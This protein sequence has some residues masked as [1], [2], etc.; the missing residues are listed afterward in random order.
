MIVRP[1]D[2]GEVARVVRWARQESVSIVTRGGNTGLVGGSIARAGAILLS[3][4]RLRHLGEVDPLARQ[5]TVGAGA[6][7]HETQEHAA[8]YGLRYP[9]DFGA[10]GSA[11]IGG[12]IATNAGGVNVVRYGMTRRQVVGVEAVLG[13][14]EVVS[15]LGGLV[16]DNTGF[17]LA[18]LLCGSEGTL[19]VVTAARLQLVPTNSHV[20]TALVSCDDIEQAVVIAAAVCSRLDCVDAAEL[21]TRS[22]VDLIEEVSGVP[23]GLPDRSAHL[24]IECSSSSDQSESLAAILAEFQDIDVSVAITG[25]HRARLWKLREDQ[26]PMINTLGA[27]FK[28]DVT[29]PLGALADFVDAIPNVVEGVRPGARTFVFGHV[30]DGNMHVNVVGGSGSEDRLTEAILGAVGARSGSI[31]AEHGIGTVKRDWLH[32]ARSAA[33]IAVMKRIKG[34]FDPDGILNSGVLLP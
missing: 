8:R 23:S 15:H 26:T 17:D 32:L 12:S 1:A 11:T 16:K 24:L 19:G 6:T 22:G 10:R 21:V 27:P 5:V 7:L 34:A 4:Q 30:A 29:V 25:T 14:G 20:A 2:V 13:T 9:V 31:S 3:T 18:G 28:F 33:E